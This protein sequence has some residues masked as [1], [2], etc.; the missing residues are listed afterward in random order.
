[1][2]KGAV[3]KIYQASISL[4]HLPAK[5]A[6]GL[7]PAKWT[8]VRRR[9]SDQSRRDESEFRSVR[10][11]FARVAR[12][13]E[14][15][16]ERLGRRLFCVLKEKR[17]AAQAGAGRI[18][19]RF[20]RNEDASKAHGGGACPFPPNC[21]SMRGFMAGRQLNT[22]A[23]R[24]SYAPLSRRAGCWATPV[25]FARDLAKLIQIADIAAVLVRIE[26]APATIETVTNTCAL[27]T[28]AGRSSAGRRSRRHRGA[29]RAQTARISPA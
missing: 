10:T 12:C 9:K 22:N 29:R 20:R 28:G 7:D 4:E 17:T 25:P 14:P 23:E 24:P 8:P 26:T 19:P 27:D 13:D 18:L 16:P 1:M 5:P 11:E 21:P 3:D 15:P 2:L 6:L